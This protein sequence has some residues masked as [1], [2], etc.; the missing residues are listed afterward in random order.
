MVFSIEEPLF[1]VDAVNELM[2]RSAEAREVHALVGPVLLDKEV[3][4]SPTA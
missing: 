2:I 3:F 1:V 4:A